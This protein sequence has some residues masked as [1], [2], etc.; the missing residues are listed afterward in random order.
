MS[1]SLGSAARLT[2]TFGLR[3]RKFQQHLLA[4]RRQVKFGNALRKLFRLAPLKDEPAQCS[5]VALGEPVR[6][7]VGQEVDRA[8]LTC[9]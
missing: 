4:I 1:R 8:R 2:A 5:E 9:A 7:R 3:R 6:L